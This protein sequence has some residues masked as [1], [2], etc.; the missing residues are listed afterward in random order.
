MMGSAAASAPAGAS[1]ELPSVRLPRSSGHHVVPGEVLVR[2]KQGRAPSRAADVHA[3][4]FH[5][6]G[7]R[8]WELVRL[9]PDETVDRAIARLRADPSVADVTGNHIY[10]GLAVPNDSLFG[11]QWGLQNTGQTISGDAGTIAGTAG[12][13]IG[14]PAAW[15]ATTGSASVIVGVVDSGVAA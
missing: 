4:S 8:G 6:L 15:G 5:A 14:A 13:D 1:D 7:V 11:R 9:E 10:H 3:R 12:A 2:F